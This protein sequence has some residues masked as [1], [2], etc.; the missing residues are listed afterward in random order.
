MNADKLW[1]LWLLVF[2]IAGALGY[3]LGWIDCK[4]NKDRQ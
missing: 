4:E 3:T 1:W 2:I